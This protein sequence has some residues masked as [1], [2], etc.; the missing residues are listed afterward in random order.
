MH[1]DDPVKHRRLGLLRGGVLLGRMTYVGGEQ[2]LLH[3]SFQA[4]PAFE[5]VAPLFAAELQTFE[6]E[7]MAH[8][9]AQYDK[10]RAPGLALELPDGSE[11]TDD[12][13]VH[14]E[15]DKARLRL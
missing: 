10:I 11:F 13:V 7:D 15:G 8:W 3:Y 6:S 5:E 2:P 12:F 9:E 14:V 1:D 4:T